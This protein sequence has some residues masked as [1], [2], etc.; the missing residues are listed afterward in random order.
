MFLRFILSLCFGIVF[1]GCADIERDNPNDPKSPNYIADAYLF[2]SSSVF[3]AP[4]SSSGGGA[5]PDAVTTDNSVSCGGQTYET[6]KIGLQTWMKSNLNY[7]VSG[8]KCGN[9]S[10]LS[11]TNTTT[12][13]TYGRLY[14]WEISKTVCPSGW[15]LPS[16][17]EWTA[18]I[19]Y[20]ES[21]GNCTGCAGTRLKAKS[22][23]WY[24][25]TGTDNH[26]FSALPGGYGSSVGNFN[27]VGSYGYWWSSTEYNSN[28]AHSRDMYYYFSNVDRGISSK[29]YLFSVRCMQN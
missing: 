20:V 13:D 2:S 19:N 18:L 9:G 17:A 16:D 5:C 10:S 4:L 29:T 22:G 26:G 25:N 24:E 11:D 8:S 3:S 21:R 23:L 12:C 15:H 1:F 28:F 14:N 6:V 27:Y 7:A